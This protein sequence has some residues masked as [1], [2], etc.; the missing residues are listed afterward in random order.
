[1]KTDL[2][3]EIRIYAEGQT[4]FV[5]LPLWRTPDGSFY[6]PREEETVFHDGVPHRVVNVEWRY[7]GKELTSVVVFAVELD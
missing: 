2:T 6:L 5:T 4:Q 7:V 3:G 1:M